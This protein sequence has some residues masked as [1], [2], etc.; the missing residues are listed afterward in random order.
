LV[1]IRIGGN[2]ALRQR[3]VRAWLA[4]G[5]VAFGGLFAFG[6]VAIAPFCMGGLAL[7]LVPFGG[8]AVGLLALGGFSLGWWSFGGCAIGWLAYGAC[9]LAWKGAVGG[10]AVAHSFALGTAA[11]ATHFNDAVAQAFADSSSFFRYGQVL[12]RHLYWVNLLWI[13]PLMLWWR[14]E[15]RRS[16]QPNP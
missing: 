2:L 14:I 5:D 4:V 6:G 16:A 15:K 9:A 10:L 3:P 7:G 1:H 12:L 13:I 11:Y 8:C